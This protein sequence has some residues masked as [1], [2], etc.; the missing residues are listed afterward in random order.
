MTDPLRKPPEDCTPAHASTVSIVTPCYNHADFLEQAIGSVLA[1]SSSDFEV[2]VVNDGSNVNTAEVVRRDSSARCTNSSRAQPL[3][4]I[5]SRQVYP[6]RH[7]LFTGGTSLILCT[8]STSRRIPWP[9]DY[10]HIFGN[11]DC[12]I[13]EASGRAEVQ[14]SKTLLRLIKEDVQINGCSRNS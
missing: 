6:V 8:V 2:I 13:Y 11:E 9:P 4:G 5:A 7:R 3:F 14:T 10:R 1:Q 12:P